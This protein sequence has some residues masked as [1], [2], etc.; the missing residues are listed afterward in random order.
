MKKLLFILMFLPLV[1]QAQKP[2][3]VLRSWNGN[4]LEP[5]AKVRT[6]NIFINIIY[7]RHPDWNPFPENNGVWDNAQHEGVNNEAIPSYLSDT[8]FMNTIYD[9]YRLTGCITRV[10]GESSFGSL[11]LTGDFVVVNINESRIADGR[12]HRGYYYYT[13]ITSFSEIISAAIRFMDS[14]GGL[15]TLYGH[16][17]GWQYGFSKG[18]KR[19]SMML[20]GCAPFIQ[21]FFRNLTEE[22]GATDYHVEETAFR[23]ICIR[24]TRSVIG[25]ADSTK[26]GVTA[27]NQICELKQ[28]RSVVT[29][30]EAE[31]SFLRV[32]RLTTSI[33]IP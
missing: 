23:R 17:M 32:L 14:C 30:R 29:N 2:E 6:L 16:E 28:L 20:D 9:P 31:R 27:M 25:L 3:A 13:D 18:Q 5:D 33:P 22:F 19:S 1:I 12:D 24:R 10:F 11:Q 8:T 4:G 15:K 7:D 21:F 26:F